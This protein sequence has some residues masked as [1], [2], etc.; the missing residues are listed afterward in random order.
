MSPP[1]VSLAAT[2]HRDN[3]NTTQRRTGGEMKRDLR[4]FHRDI[5]LFLSLILGIY[6]EIVVSHYH[7]IAIS[8]Y[9]SILV[10]K[11]VIASLGPLFSFF[12]MTYFSL[13]VFHYFSTKKTYVQILILFIIALV[14]ICL[15]HLVTPPTVLLGGHSSYFI[16]PACIYSMILTFWRRKRE[17]KTA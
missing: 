7:E 16:L 13:T 3:P 4:F 5:Y 1:E 6:R 15:S 12:L 11:H 17:G 8:Q 14:W 9:T 2:K 10:N